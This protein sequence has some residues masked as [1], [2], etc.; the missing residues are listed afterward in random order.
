MLAGLVL[1]VVH[2]V[3]VVFVGLVLV[4]VHGVVVVHGCGS[5][6]CSAR[7]RGGACWVGAW[8]G[9]RGHGGARG[10]G[11]AVDLPSLCEVNKSVQL[12]IVMYLVI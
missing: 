4:L 5:G 7:G 10:G 8:G 9:A 11:G 1:V 3:V 12:Y 6:C 2:M